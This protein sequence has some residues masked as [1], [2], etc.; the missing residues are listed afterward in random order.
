[1]LLPKTRRII[2][3][4]ILCLT[5]L[6]AGAQIRYVKP[7]ASGTG[8]GSSWA[9]ASGDLQLMINNSNSG[10]QV[11]VASGTHRPRRPANNL[12]VVDLNNRD[13]AFVLKPGVRIYGGFN[14]TE[15]AFFQRNYT[16]NKTVLSGDIGTVN[17]TADN[18]YHVLISS[19]NVGT[20]VLDGFTITRGNANGTNTNL[21]VNLQNV[22]R[23]NGGGLYF[24]ASTPGIANCTLIANSALE[25]G[26]GAYC[27]VGSAPKFNNCIFTDNNADAGGG[28]YNNISSPS[29]ILCDFINNNAGDGAGIFNLTSSPTITNCSFTINNA[30]G[31]GGGMFNSNAS[32]PV[33]TNCVFAG[34]TVTANTGGGIYNIG[35]S[36]EV[37]NC[38]FSGNKAFL[39]GGM[40]N[41]ASASPTITN[42]TFSGNIATGSVGGISNYNSSIPVISNC[43]I[44][45]NT[46]P[47]INNLNVVTGIIVR[48]SLIEGGYASGTNIITSNPLFIA[49][50]PAANAPTTAGNYRL[51]KCSPAI[52]AGSNSLVPGGLITD[53][54][55]NPRLMA[56]VDIGAFE[57]QPA[58]PSPS[59]I[60]YVD[61][62]KNGNGSSWASALPEVADALLAAKYNTDISEI[63]VAK[64]TYHPR[65]NAADGSTYNFCLPDTMN[66]D[67]AFVM[68]DNVKLYG[69]FAGGETDTSGR[70]F[71]LN[72]T[73]LS[74]DFN[75]NDIPGNA[76]GNGNENGAHVMISSGDVG[77]AVLNG[78]TM[79][80]GNAGVTPTINVN[81]R[82]IDRYYGGGMYN[83]ASSPSISNCIF[84]GNWKAYG[85]GMYN[86]SSSSP[87]INNCLFKNNGV[88]NFG[89][90]MLNVNSSPTIA[91]CNFLDNYS[92]G[93]G[94]AIRT[95]GAGLLNISNC[96][97]SD[98]RAQ[99]DW[100][101]AM[102]NYS[103]ANIT[104]CT[105]FSN[106][107]EFGGAI[108]NS[109]S[110]VSVYIANCVFSGNFANRGSAI[111]NNAVSP[112][113]INCVFSS[114]AVPNGG[115]GCI[116][117][118]ASSSPVFT[119][120]TWAENVGG[121][122][123][124]SS[125]TATVH[126]SIIW[127]S[128]NNFPPGSGTTVN[129]S[130][131]PG[132]Y[133]GTGNLYTDP[134]FLAPVRWPSI[135][136]ITACILVVLRSMQETMP[137]YRAQ[138]QQILTVNPV[139][140]IPS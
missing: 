94:G 60:V 10:D 66:M 52:N 82:T 26:G 138:L 42:C 28:L 136:G 133:P 14:G 102:E 122:I 30:S 38:V 110:A 140:L 5:T 50:Q 117:N 121:A 18:C 73:I 128:V 118:A 85:A 27:T 1:M 71:I 63:W 75:S 48:Y 139:L 81:G 123:I 101:G 125:S 3:C 72:E 20:A 53:H 45:G 65:Y 62:T 107:A 70:D 69:G 36:P 76:I 54:D 90:G 33:V 43:I 100:G 116:Y 41:N 55:G 23:Q 39:G 83:I 96:I 126:N 129:H 87:I 127:A 99:Y 103:P 8:T 111:Y 105:F 32:S 95:A 74:C 106:N 93:G 9:N 22:N 104:N 61:S 79:R 108:Y 13:N 44:W 97:F 24:I 98:N 86:T 78:F 2:S 21:L 35:S 109:S 64:G 80:G 124:N 46:A 120:C 57:Y 47:S 132:G 131:V 40:G 59:G 17:V 12:G 29:I 15:F 31:S 114:N 89:G 34:N 137:M 6:I 56:V 91:N 113:V 4:V 19:G 119:N 25:K 77:T 58:V 11:W 49:P 135:G 51:Q 88:P 134:R 84:S 130:I 16:T 92:N 68:V 112:E 67:N 115:Q 7:V 37:Y